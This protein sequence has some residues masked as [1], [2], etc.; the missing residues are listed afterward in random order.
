M[1]TLASGDTSGGYVATDFFE[2]AAM[3][4]TFILLGKWLEARA[5]AATGAKLAALAAL[6][7]AEAELVEL[8][9]DNG[10]FEVVSEEIVD[11]RLVHVG[12]A[13]RVRP[14]GRV[15]ADGAVVS[16]RHSSSVFKW[17]V[18]VL[19]LPCRFRVS[20]AFFRSVVLFAD[21]PGRVRAAAAFAGRRISDRCS[22]RS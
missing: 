18:Q 15:P 22:T 3:L 10:T 7:P 17:A 19:G 8:R 2:S 4:V 16:V 13:L 9:Q 11:A 12:D 21:L 20:L 14:G 6:T 1:P 5:S